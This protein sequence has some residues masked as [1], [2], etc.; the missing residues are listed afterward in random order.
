MRVPAAPR[1]LSKNHGRPGGRA[2]DQAVRPT[3][4]HIGRRRNRCRGLL[5]RLFEQE[6][7]RLV[8]ADVSR[9]ARYPAFLFELRPRHRHSLALLA[10]YLL[11]FAVYFFLRGPD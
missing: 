3:S 10:R 11:N 8:G 9:D 5:A 4:N 1:A 2:A 7:E 6:I